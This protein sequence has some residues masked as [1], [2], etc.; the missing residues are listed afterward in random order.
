MLKFLKL[1]NVGVGLTFELMIEE[2]VVNCG[3]YRPRTL[4]RMKV[5]MRTR[6]TR[7]MAETELTVLSS[8]TW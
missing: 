3:D 2:V 8:G 1:V 5:A 6:T 7:I 4:E